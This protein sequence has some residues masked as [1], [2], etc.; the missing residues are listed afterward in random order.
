MNKVQGR[1]DNLSTDLAI[2]QNT[3]S[4]TQDDLG[5]AIEEQK[6]AETARN[7]AQG[8]AIDANARLSRAESD[9]VDQRQRADGHEANANKLQAELV[10]A[11][12]FS[13]SWRLFQQANGTQAQIRQKLATFAD[14][15]NQRANFLA[16][17]V[18]LL[19][20]IEKLGVELSRYTGTSVKVT[21]PQNLHGTV[22]AVDAQFDFVVLDIG[23]SQGVREH[24][25][26]L[27]SRG[28]KLIGKLRI[29]DVK[30]DHSIAN[31]LPDWKQGEIQTGDLVIVGN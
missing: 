17:N 23:E 14:V 8:K 4:T 3:L 30:K 13:E 9:L 26:L 25:E 12:K 7:E 15:N 28:E 5:K 27:V 24:G 16:E 6:V 11:R 22:T 10:D 1:I 31:I 19:S 20:Q 2:T 18:I 21:L 29:L